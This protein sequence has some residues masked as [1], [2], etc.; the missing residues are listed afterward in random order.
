MA[1][2]R[3]QSSDIVVCTVID[4]EQH[5]KEEP[6]STFSKVSSTEN[7]ALIIIN[8]PK[9]SPKSSFES[10]GTHVSTDFSATNSGSSLTGDS[11]YKDIIGA[12]STSAIGSKLRGIL[13]GGT[14]GSSS[15]N[16]THITPVPMS[17]TIQPKPEQHL[18]NGDVSSDTAADDETSSEAPGG[19]T[20]DNTAPPQ[21][22]V[23]PPPP[24]PRSQRQGQYLHPSHLQ[25]FSDSGLVDNDAS[26]YS[27]L[28][29]SHSEYQFPVVTMNKII[30]QPNES[31][32]QSIS[33][34]KDSKEQTNHRRDSKQR[35]PAP[36]RSRSCTDMQR[37]VRV[38]TWDDSDDD[39]SIQPRQD[40][41]N[42]VL[43]VIDRVNRQR[44]PSIDGLKSVLAKGI[45]EQNVGI[46]LSKGVDMVS[47]SVRSLSSS[48][49]QRSSSVPKRRSRSV[50]KRS[51]SAKL[52]ND[53]SDPITTFNQTNLNSGNTATLSRE[54]LPAN[55]KFDP[56][57]GRC[58][59]H[60]SVIMAQKSKFRKG[61]W[62]M[63]KAKCPLCCEECKRKEHKS[64]WKDDTTLKATLSSSP[65]KNITLRNSLV[66]DTTKCS[67]SDADSLHKRS[68]SPPDHKDLVAT[69]ASDDTS[70]VRVSRMPYT[71]SWGESG[72]YM[73]E[74]NSDGRPQGRG[75]LR[76]KTGNVIGGMWSNGY[77]NDNN[78]ER[79]KGK[80][81][82]G[83][84]MKRDGNV[85]LEESRPSVSDGVSSRSYRRTGSGGN[86]RSIAASPAPMMGM[87]PNQ[88]FSQMSPMMFTGQNIQHLMPYY[89]NSQPMMLPKA[90]FQPIQKQ[91]MAMYRTHHT[92]KM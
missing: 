26:R 71:T 91:N 28:P 54:I 58:K 29:N 38:T 83:F 40:L 69:A 34:R 66:T 5:G 31:P 23:P 87:Y 7:A 4:K 3:Q 2:S 10:H 20:K 42:S 14:G 80:M 37:P 48:R 64:G 51:S 16:K 86:A 15:K 67:S 17:C 11:L 12:Q 72:W 75:R 79:R 33:I 84:D 68:S 8:P 92:D 57:T 44:R 46:S 85:G 32:R 56:K 82:S 27:H 25:K 59:K 61:C 62:E 73:G 77:S 55:G 6:V 52:V 13:R 50:P 60:P 1:L 88:A 22:I 18:K 78:L 74:V 65:P 21:R 63:I 70:P 39:L 30:C 47:S 43:Q 36:R 81:Q 89:Y 24:R 19:N 76:T 9:R 45:N 41:V 90:G 53:I 35:T 49:Q